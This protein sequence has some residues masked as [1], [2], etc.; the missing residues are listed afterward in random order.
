MSTSGRSTFK[1]E[2]TVDGMV[3]TGQKRDREAVRKSQ[4]KRT[5]REEVPGSCT[6]T[7]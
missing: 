3:L 5:V 7:G 6:P 1:K 2:G 4:R